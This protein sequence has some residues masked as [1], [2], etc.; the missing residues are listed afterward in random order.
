M[1]CCPTSKGTNRHPVLFPR[2]LPA[3]R[4]S[5]AER[6]GLSD[7]R[8]PV[9]Q[10]ERG[11][12]LSDHTADAPAPGA[13]GGQPLPCA[14]PRGSVRLPAPAAPPVLGAGVALQ[15]RLAAAGQSELSARPVRGAGA[16]SRR[17]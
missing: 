3:L 9:A 16:S 7:Q 11:P 15:R 13:G 1:A 14:D 2:S 17:A 4:R 10:V 8:T 12:V 5:R 6:L